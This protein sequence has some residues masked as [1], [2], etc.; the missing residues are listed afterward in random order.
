MR[1]VGPPLTDEQ[2]HELAVSIRAGE[3]APGVVDWKTVDGIIEPLL[4]IADVPPTAKAKAAAAAVA[5]M[6]R[7]G[8]ALAWR[9]QQVNPETMAAIFDRLSEGKRRGG[10]PGSP[11][12]HHAWAASEINPTGTT[13]VR[14]PLKNR[15]CQRCGLQS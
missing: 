10:C 7:Q 11:D 2:A 13:P 14:I 15:R 1:Q 6:R 9:G 12:G 4:A 8:D 3:F 5:L